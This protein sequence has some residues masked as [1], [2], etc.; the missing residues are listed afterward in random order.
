MDPDHS[1]VPRQHEIK[2]RPMCR[3]L[4]RKR[5]WLGMTGMALLAGT[6]FGLGEQSRPEALVAVEGNLH[7]GQPAPDFELLEAA[8]GRN[9]KLSSFRGKRAVVLIFGSLT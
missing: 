3:A 9:V 5:T 1:Q 2:R 8:S 7:V 4:F 6:Y